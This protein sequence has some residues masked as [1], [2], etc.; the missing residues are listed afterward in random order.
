MPLVDEELEEVGVQ[1][2]RILHHILVLLYLLA[3]L[4]ED[5]ESRES[6]EAFGAE[7]RHLR[8]GHA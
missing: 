8:S 6:V 1:T 7:V 2:H 3:F 4:E 5:R